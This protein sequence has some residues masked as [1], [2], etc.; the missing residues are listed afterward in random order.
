[1]KTGATRVAAGLFSGDG[2]A[3]CIIVWHGKCM[4]KTVERWSSS[5]ASEVE[6]NL[7]E[8]FMNIAIRSLTT[9]VLLA[10]A[11]AA[12]PIVQAHGNVTPQAVDVSTLKPLGET[13]RDENPYRGDQEAVRVGMS[14]YNQNCARCHGLEAISG[15]IAPDLRKLDMDKE[16]DQYFLQSVLHGKVRNG[17]VYMP[18]FEGVFTQEAIWA[19]RSY[20]DT[21][22]EEPEAP[23]NAMETL[24]KKD[25]CLSC[26]TVDVRLVGPAYQD[27]AKKYAKNKKAQARLLA[28]LKKGGSGTW[29]KVPMPAMDAVPEEDLKAL[30]QWILASAG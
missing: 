27:V 6:N 15:G 13:K 2:S 19:I 24:A 25:G 14:A 8:I 26:H 30:I 29:G 7:E 9:V 18:P 3:D 16:T 20:L 4:D 5:R 11:L 22:H 23:L 12:T 10:G 28:K 17:A 21:R 1:L